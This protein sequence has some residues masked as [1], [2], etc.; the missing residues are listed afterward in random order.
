MRV[1]LDGHEVVLDEEGEVSELGD[2]FQVRTSEG[3]FSGVALREGNNI[4]VSYRGQTFCFVTQKPRT[5][6][7][8]AGGDEVR[9]PMPGLVIEVLANVGDVVDLG[10]RLVVI[11]AMKTQQPLLSPQEG[12]IL[13]LLVTQGQQVQQGELLVKLEPKEPG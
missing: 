8:A 5:A 2:R 11:E 6:S 3:T 1:Y 9:A 7:A 4:H 12:K 13:Q 10:Q